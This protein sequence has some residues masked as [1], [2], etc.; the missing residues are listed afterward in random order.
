MFIWIPA[1]GIALVM[2]LP[3]VYLVVRT[4]DAGNDAWGI[5]FSG[6]T[7]EILLRT[8]LLVVLVTSVCAVLGVGLAWLTVRTDLPFRGL[9]T[10]LTALPLVIPSYVFA[11]LVVLALGP[12]GI[13]QGWLEPLGVDR[14]PDIIGLP[15]AVFTLSLLSFPYVLL[16][17]RAAFFRVDPALEE[18]S[19][20]L[21]KGAWTTFARVTLPM[22]RP[23]IVAGVLLV[24][25]YTL[26]DFGAVAMLGYR[27]FTWSIFSEFQASIDRTVAAALSLVLVSLA[28]TLVFVETWTRGRGRIYRVTPGA[29]RDA[30]RV[31]LGRWR[32]PAA[33]LVGILVMLSLGAPLGILLFWVVRGLRAGESLSFLWSNTLNSVTISLAAAVVAA[34]ASIP[35]AVLAVRFPSRLSGALERMTFIGFALPG[36]AVALAFVFFASALAQPIY[37]TSFLLVVA[38]VVLFLPA[39]VGV[40][41]ASLKQVS[42]RIEEAAR[43]LGKSSLQAFRLVT[44]P[45]LARGVL[46]GA[47]LVFLLTMK[48]LPATL[49][50]GPIGFRTLATS[51]WSAWNEVFIARAA[52]ASL[53]LVL[54]ASVPMAFLVLRDRR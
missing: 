9:F 39:A 49:I 30:A 15:G 23:S 14:V 36:V 21:G 1:A 44:L 20:G 33:A 18:A 43:G 3:P 8:V 19:R 17:V 50:L 29:V 27:T 24:A 26:S 34:I 13:L 53:L 25:L 42:P 12:K 38:Y 47:A 6:R 52:F 45:L 41:Q 40:T 32:W 22:L 7:L 51:V 37:Q 28:L 2:L 46:A 5:L 48:E 11:F 16:P 35:I 31:S 4:F 10:V 54:T